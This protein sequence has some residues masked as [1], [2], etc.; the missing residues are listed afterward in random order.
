[1]GQN[2][3]WASPL[4]SNA[5]KQMVRLLKGWCIQLECVK[6]DVWRKMD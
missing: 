2:L 3:V 5:P 1:M 4:C 6:L